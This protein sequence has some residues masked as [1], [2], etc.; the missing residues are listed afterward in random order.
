MAHK[1]QQDQRVRQELQVHKDRKD[2]QE[3]TVGIQMETE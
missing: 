3:L 1:V 2:Q